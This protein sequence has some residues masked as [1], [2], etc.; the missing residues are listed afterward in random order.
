MSSRIVTNEL[1]HG[2]L[3]QLLS[4]DPSTGKF[5]W[6]VAPR[7]GIAAGTSAG[8]P[9]PDGYQKIAIRERGYMA[10]RLAWFYVHGQWPAHQID[11]INGVRNDNRISN[12]REVTHA[13]NLHNMPRARGYTWHKKD[14][15]WQAQ[16]QINGKY[17]YL[18]Y[19]ATEQEA[20]D[21]YLKAKTIFHPTAPRLNPNPKESP[22]L[23]RSTHHKQRHSCR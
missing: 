22:C 4:Y 17:V 18:G 8:T 21:A 3:I 10:H 20:R 12:L 14:R 15:K 2:E 9:R 7:R 23:T 5:V 16:I 13:E 19:F 11:H 6:N 1:T